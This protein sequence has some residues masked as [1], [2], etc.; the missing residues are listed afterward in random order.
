MERALEMV[1]G[2]GGLYLFLSVIGM[3]AVEWL[4]S[5]RDMRA[6]HLEKGFIALLGKD[7]TAVLNHPLVKSLGRASGRPGDLP[8]YVPREIFTS[9]VMDLAAA[10]ALAP[11]PG[12]QKTAVQSI[13]ELSTGDPAAMKSRIEDWFDAGME[14]LAGQYKRSVQ[15]VTRIVVALLVLAFNADTLEIG[16]ELWVSPATRA[17]AIEYGKDLLEQ[18]QTTA[19]GKLSC[20]DAAK[21]IDE[22]R[23]AYPLGWSWPVL[24]S[25]DDAAA[26]LAKLLGLFATFLAASLG[27]PFWFD[28]LRRM[29]PGLRQAGPKPDED[30]KPPGPDQAPAA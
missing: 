21:S 3:A 28:V 30:G 2:L 8:S 24:R 1:I 12:G 27:A 18:C 4:A 5:F 6:K 26:I 16:R 7:A 10:G 14:R 13:A 15:R 19:D 25:L 9:A 20:P 17:G 23:A 29:A 22:A 11:L